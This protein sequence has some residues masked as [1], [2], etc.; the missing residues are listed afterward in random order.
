MKKL[1]FY[2]TEEAQKAHKE[3]TTMPDGSDR[4]IIVTIRAR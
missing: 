3:L 4:F 1:E 2:K